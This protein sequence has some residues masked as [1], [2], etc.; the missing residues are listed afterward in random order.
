M[1]GQGLA[2][3]MHNRR[4]LPCLCCFSCVRWISTF[5][6]AFP[7]P[8]LALRKAKASSDSIGYVEK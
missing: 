1:P 8:Q 4:L 6:V 7:C 3:F 2:P 5:A